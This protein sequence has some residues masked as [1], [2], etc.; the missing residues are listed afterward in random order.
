MVA[1]NENQIIT[2]LTNYFNKQPDLSAAYLFGSRTKGVARETSD[3]DIGVLFAPC[4]SVHNRFTRKLEINGDLEDLLEQEIDVI[5]LESVD[6]FFL[7]QVMKSK[8]LLVDLDVNR[9]VSFEVQKRREF[10]DRM[11]FYRLYHQQ[12]LDRLE[13]QRSTHYNG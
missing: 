6:L 1:N 11:H 9:R 5:D 8:Y 3:V 13:K 10:F 12:A 4:I 7:H 2:K